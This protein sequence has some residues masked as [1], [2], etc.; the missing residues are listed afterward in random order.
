[1]I[2]LTIE[3]RKDMLTWKIITNISN[4]DPWSITKV[5]PTEI[6]LTETMLIRKG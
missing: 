4:A 3:T 6:K 1:M 5:A 2:P